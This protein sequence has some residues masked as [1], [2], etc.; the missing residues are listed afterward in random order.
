MSTTI[1]EKGPQTVTVK[2]EATFELGDNV[3]IVDAMSAAENLIALAS[4]RP[5]GGVPRT[6]TGTVVIGRQKFAL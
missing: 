1:K 2:L 6:V 4:E 5:D 3:D